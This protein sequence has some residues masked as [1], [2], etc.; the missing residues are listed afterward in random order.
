MNKIIYCCECQK[1]INA[2]LTNGKEI[3]PHREDLFEKFFWIC[4]NCNNY[5]GTHGKTKDKTRPLGVIPS[6]EIKQLRKKIHSVID[7]LWK[8]KKIKRQILYKKISEKIGKEYHTAEIR[9]AEEGIKI[10]KIVLNLK[11]EEV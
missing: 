10:L 6:R 11:S 2:R 5:V 3:Y 9:T 8:N 4:E 7:P 1:E